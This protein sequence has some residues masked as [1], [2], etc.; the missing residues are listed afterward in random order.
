ML[1]RKIIIDTVLLQGYC[2]GFEKKVA[3]TAKKDLTI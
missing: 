3:I 2:S 1:Y